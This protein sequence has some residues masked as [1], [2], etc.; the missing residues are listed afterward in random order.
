MRL[1]GQDSTAVTSFG[2]WSLM[3]KVSVP[4]AAPALGL[5]V[6]LPPSSGVEPGVARLLRFCDPEGNQVELVAGVDTVHD[7]YGN[8]DVKPVGLNHVVRKWADPVD[9]TAT[10]LF[11]VP[12]GADGPSGVLVCAEDNVTPTPIPPRRRT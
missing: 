8:R 11:Q 12:G 5:Q 3:R 9:R 1:S 4:Q 10:M 6:T 7:P 2:P